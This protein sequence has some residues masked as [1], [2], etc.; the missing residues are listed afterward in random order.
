MRKARWPSERKGMAKRRGRGWCGRC[1]ADDALWVNNVSREYRRLLMAGALEKVT[2]SVGG[3]GA[4]SRKVTRK[5]VRRENG[6]GQDARTTEELP[7]TRMLR[8]RIRYFTDGAVIGNRS[9]VN[10][11][12]EN[13]R[14]RF[15]SRRRDG[16]R[17]MHGSASPAAGALWSLRD[18]KKGVV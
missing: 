2:E 8:C 17:Q 9:F 14:E 1:E 11:A 4:M 5:G 16:A 3:D 13:A 6:G 7:F 15:G 18:L 12:F 10:E